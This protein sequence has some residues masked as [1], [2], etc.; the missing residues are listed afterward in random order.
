[1]AM[2]YPGWPEIVDLVNRSRAPESEP[3][4]G[5]GSRQLASLEMAIGRPLPPTLREWLRHC[6]GAPAGPGGLYGAGLA[7]GSFLS[8][9]ARHRPDWPRGWIPVAGDGCGNDYIVDAGHEY[10]DTDAVYFW[11]AY[12]D[13]GRPSY[14]VASDLRLFLMFLL[15]KDLAYG[16]PH[17]WPFD[18]RYLL[19]RDP[20]LARV[21]D[22]SLLP[23]RADEVGPP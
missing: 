7:A 11:D 13:F 22:A 9:E 17:P 5:A 6:N 8:I 14:V 21:R 18:S 3:P 15:E 2:A 10:I 1:M 16:D 4:R 20:D 23:W 12:H 19:S